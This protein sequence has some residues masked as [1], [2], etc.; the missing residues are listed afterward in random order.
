MKIGI[1]SQWYPPEPPNIPADLATELA[2]RGHA[3]RVLMTQAAKRVQDHPFVEMADIDGIASLAIG[4]S[5]IRQGR[6][7]RA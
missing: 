1:V 7:R 6:I 4:R 3:V 5:A 2:A